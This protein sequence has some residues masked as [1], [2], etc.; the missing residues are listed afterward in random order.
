[1][2]ILLKIKKDNIKKT[3]P[4]VRLLGMKKS[5][6]VLLKN[7]HQQIQKNNFTIIQKPSLAKKL[8]APDIFSLYENDITASHLYQQIIYHKFHYRLPI[9]YKNNLIIL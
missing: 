9:E 5:S 6:G 2:H 1:M 3:A 7:I 8:L 4:Y